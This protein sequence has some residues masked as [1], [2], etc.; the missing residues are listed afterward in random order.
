M[1]KKRLLVFA[2]VVTMV[3]TMFAFS[4]C[5]K[6]E[7]VVIGISYMDAEE[8][9]EDLQAYVDVVEQ[10]GAIA[11]V[12]PLV[13]TEEEA[14][15]AVDDIDALIVT[16]GEDINPAH[17][18][19]QPAE[20]LEGVNEARDTSDLLVLAEALDEDM[21]ILLTCR[22]HQMLNVLQGGTLYQDL[23]TMYD[24]D[25]AHRDPAEYDFTYHDITIEEGSL[26]AGIVGDTTLNVNSWHH[27]G[28]DKLG[29]GLKVTA[30]TAD[31]LIEAMEMPGKTFVVSVQFHP[32]WIVL[33]HDG[34]QLEFFTELIEQAEA[35]RAD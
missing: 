9:G 28:I 13:A 35:Y 27:Q 5:G 20:T 4:S 34:A 22:G 21:P 1:N 25:I 2:T 32:E 30:T 24:S 6:E 26:L 23:P 3:F 10:A 8:M 15:D 33:E 18:G 7:P 17:Y 14:E 31:G 16:G 19:Q 12:L 29:E 11:Q